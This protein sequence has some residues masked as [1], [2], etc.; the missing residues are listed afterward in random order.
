MATSDSITILLADDSEFFRLGLRSSLEREEDF[1]VVGECETG[2]AA[3]AAVERLNPRVVLL[4]VSLPDMSGFVACR[5]ILDLAHRTRVVLLTSAFSNEKAVDA[6]MSVSAA[7]LPKNADREDLVRTVRCNAEGG[8][9][10]IPEGAER[11]L[12]FL[13]FNKAGQSTSPQDPVSV[14]CLT[15]REKQIVLLIVRGNT[16]QE[17]AEGIGVS[18]HTVR[19][20]LSRIFT[21]LNVSRRAELGTY[22][23]LIGMLGEA[24]R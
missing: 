13:R 19:N 22:A 17:V 1:E 8:L 10:L 18:P 21:K 23:A 11:I 20:H 14:N 24:D 6:M 3:V 16:N 15:D 12:Q 5:R 2:E 9:Y 4:S 7:Y